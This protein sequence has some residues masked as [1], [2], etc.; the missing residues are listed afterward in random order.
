MN[1]LAYTNHLLCDVFALTAYM[2]E[3]RDRQ[4][5]SLTPQILDDWA[6]VG[7]FMA[8][9]EYPPF[10][11]LGQAI[12]EK[13]VPERELVRTF[14]EWAAAASEMMLPVLEDILANRRIPE[15]QRALV[16]TTPGLAQAAMQETAQ[17][18]GA[19]WPRPVQLSGV[20]WRTNNSPVGGFTEIERRTLPVVDPELDDLP[21]REDYIQDARTQRAVLSHRYL[22]DWNNESLSV[23]D[24]DGK[25]SQFANLWRIRTCGQ[26]NRLLDVEY[27]RTNLLFQI[28][29]KVERIEAIN[30]HLER[31]FMFVGVVYRQ[32]LPDLIPG[33]FKNPMGM[34]TQ[35]Y[36]Q[37][38]LYVPRRRLVW[39]MLGGTPPVTPPQMAGV[40]GQSVVLPPRGDVIPGVPGSA[41]RIVVRQH[42]APFPDHWDLITQNWSTQLVPATASSLPAILSTP[43]SG[44]TITSVTPPDLRDL[45]DQDI[46][47]L[48]HH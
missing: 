17:R 47:W 42:P 26:L 41:E 37:T 48:S 28:R 3:A 12:S 34:D 46:E 11:E 40:P 8:T 24:R 5:E 29:T 45:S 35:A 27:P 21:N 16:Q 32:K 2:R 30:P 6:K 14:G 1:T 33:I 36:S 10:A 39:G 31:D 20:L 38:M 15:F 22:N 7:P 19:A 43:P 4:A 23:F 13:N 25:M 44:L 9:S 18:H